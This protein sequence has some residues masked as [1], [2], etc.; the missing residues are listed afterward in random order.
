M[1]NIIRVLTLLV[2]SSLAASASA[3]EVDETY[4]N[5]SLSSTPMGSTTASARR[6]KKEQTVPAK[7]D[8]VYPVRDRGHVARDRGAI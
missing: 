7:Y 1:R 2:V 6:S 5:T 4:S 8:V 3:R